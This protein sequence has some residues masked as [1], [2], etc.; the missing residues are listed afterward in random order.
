MPRTSSWIWTLLA[1]SCACSSDADRLQGREPDGGTSLVEPK[2]SETTHDVDGEERG[3]K[4]PAGGNSG[5]EGSIG[6]CAETEL[7]HD[8]L[9]DVDDM[10]HFSA[11]DVLALAAQLEVALRWERLDAGPSLPEGHAMLHIRVESLGEGP[12]VFHCGDPNYPAE[13]SAPPRMEIPVALILRTDDGVL[14]E[15]FET[16]LVATHSM[17]AAIDLTVDAQQLSGS[18]G[19]EVV[20]FYTGG[21]RSLMLE[22]R[23]SAAGPTGWIGGPFSPNASD[24]CAYT[25]YATWPADAQCWPTQQVSLD[26]DDALADVVARVS[27]SYELQ[28]SDGT[29]GTASLEV[30]LAA[31]PACR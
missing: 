3:P 24:P 4:D 29:K 2:E 10:L 28:R 22:L 5:S 11:N 13:H 17:Q 26:D 16:T 8:S 27:R 31:S 14:D 15:R 19:A 30:T 20:S 25:A 12:S 6:P 23:F 7:V 21:T 18:L 1:L 9:D